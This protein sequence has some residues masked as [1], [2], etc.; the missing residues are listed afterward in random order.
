MKFKV[1]VVL[2]LA[3][4]NFANSQ[5]KI[6]SNPNEIDPASIVELESTDK[7]FVLTRLTTVQMQAITPL[8]GAVI[9]NTDTQCVHYYDGTS[10]INLCDGN[11]SSSFSFTD[12]GDGTIT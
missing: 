4:F 8:N 11:T 2:F 10:W 6:G 12:N 3:I 9:Y 5:V 7:A 1:L